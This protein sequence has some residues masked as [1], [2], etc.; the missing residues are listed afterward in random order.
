M[1]E[2][3]PAKDKD[4]ASKW[5][6]AHE[7]GAI[8]RMAGV[9]DLD[10]WQAGPGELVLPTK[11]PDGLILAWRGGRE[12]PEPYVVEVVTYADRRDAEQALRDALLVYL[13]RGE[14]PNLLVL[15]LRPRGRVRVPDLVLRTSPDG[16]TEVQCRW[17]VVELW[18]VPAEP[19]LAAQDPGMMPWVPLMHADEPPETVL[20]R[21]RQVI[22]RHAAPA[23]HDPLIA[24]T[25]VYTRLRYKDPKLLSVL[26]VRTA[27]IE[28]PL[29]R[30]ILAERSHK[31]ILRI[32]Q[33]RLGAVPPDVEAEVKS[34]L[35]ETVL[36]SVIDLAVACSSVEQFG[37]ELRAIPR[38]PEPWDPADEPDPEPEPEA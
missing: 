1:P 19:V 4:K 32:L 26:G 10:R 6:I 8:L 21:C 18:R 9:T 24:V 23:E 28:S 33:R 36:D 11:L 38:P 29:I 16:A 22:D 34:I 14:V 13:V 27:M 17:R 30:E 37:A 35:D 2:P 5:L 25:Q 31:N 12:R 20:R 3:T 7:G 15:V